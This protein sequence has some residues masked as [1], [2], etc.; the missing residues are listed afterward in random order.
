MVLCPQRERRAGPT[1]G[2]LL[3]TVEL[4]TDSVRENSAPLSPPSDSG[5]GRN[6][7]G[8]EEQVY[9]GNRKNSLKV[10]QY[11]QLPFLP[12][13]VWLPENRGGGHQMDQKTDASRKPG[14][15]TIK[16]GSLEFECFPTHYLI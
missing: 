4:R 7:D 9:F 6:H 8:L 15:R 5:R 13:S 1:E 2:L 10:F 3:Y 16:T 12:S 14:N 11:L